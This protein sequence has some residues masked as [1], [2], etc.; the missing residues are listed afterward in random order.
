MT[1]AGVRTTP[2]LRRHTRTIQ[3]AGGAMLV[4]VGVLLAIG[5]VGIFIAWLRVPV[6]GFTVPL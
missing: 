2:W 5:V 3:L 1:T 6:G 4:L